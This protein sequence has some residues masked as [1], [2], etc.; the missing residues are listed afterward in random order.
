MKIVERNK[1]INSYTMGSRIEN[2]V[3]IIDITET[4]ENL[5]N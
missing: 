3:L 2:L 1:N 5:S 4:C